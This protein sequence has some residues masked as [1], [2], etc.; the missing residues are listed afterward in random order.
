MEQFKSKLDTTTISS[1]SKS[2]DILAKVYQRENIDSQVKEILDKVS[3]RLLLLSKA[4]EEE[5]FDRIDAYLDALFSNIVKTLETLI[6]LNDKN[7]SEAVSFMESAY[8]TIQQVKII[9]DKAGLINEF[10]ELLAKHNQGSK[11]LH[12]YDFT[13]IQLYKNTA[14][15]NSS[16]QQENIVYT[17]TQI[18]IGDVGVKNN[19]RPEQE[20]EVP[21]IPKNNVPWDL[22]DHV[23]QSPAITEAF[24][25]AHFE[26]QDEDK[27][28]DDQ[29]ISQEQNIQKEDNNHSQGMEK[30]LSDTKIIE[31]VPVTLKAGVKAHSDSKKTVENSD[32]VLS[33]DQQNQYSESVNKDETILVT[34]QKIDEIEKKAKDDNQN[35]VTLPQGQKDLKVT[36]KLSDEE[37]FSHLPKTRQGTLIME[38]PQNRKES[39]SGIKLPVQKISDHKFPKVIINISDEQIAKVEKIEKAEVV[40]PSASMQQEEPSLPSTKKEPKV[41][42][43]ISTPA[44]TLIKQELNHSEDGLSPLPEYF[45]KPSDYLKTKD[46]STLLTQETNHITH[47]KRKRASTIA[48]LGALSLGGAVGGYRI[49][50]SVSNTDSTEAPNQ[51]NKLAT[52]NKDLELQSK[53]SD[54]KTQSQDNKVKEEIQTE[55]QSEKREKGIY[56]MDFDAPG[57]NQYLAT[58][59]QSSGLVATIKDIAGQVKV[60]YLQD[61]QEIE[62]AKAKGKFVLTGKETD[63]EKRLVMMEAFLVHALKQ[64]I[65]N[66]WVRGFF[67][68][69][70][71]SLEYFKKTGQWEKNGAD[72]GARKFFELFQTPVQLVAPPD[73]IG[74]APDIDPKSNPVLEQMKTAAPTFKLA[75]EEAAR[76][77]QQE[78]DPSKLVVYNDFNEIKTDICRRIRDIGIKYKDKDA[79]SGIAFMHKA[80]CIK[81]N[82]YNNYLNKSLKYI[83]PVTQDQKP[84]QYQ[85]TTPQKQVVP[86]GGPIFNNMINS[87]FRFELDQKPANDNNEEQTPSSQNEA[88]ESP[89]QDGIEKTK[90]AIRS[91]IAKI[92]E[93]YLSQ[94]VAK[95]K[96]T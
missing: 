68:N 23:A 49:Y 55:S 7:R 22:I 46:H 24:Q 4:F 85:T 38:K 29:V 83:V 35:A 26:I 37:A 92:K 76:Q 84:A 63:I 41:Q 30:D 58:I 78:T 61:N 86:Q 77:M 36:T 2:F 59:K 93:K 57:Y 94:L 56:K 75:F 67:Q 51:S 39:Q 10:N 9:F 62:A 44:P 11:S 5:D 87:P 40:Q 12:E 96:N 79:R 34:E 18:G 81:E 47:K 71:T 48:L 14:N 69:Q 54:T 33:I 1:I 3:Q 16:K 80:W 72:L 70:L 20:I 89:I 95:P 8:R 13:L 73:I 74:Y 27:T 65:D 6:R 32:T 15:L 88:I 42:D 53:T 21:E 45:P 52:N 28:I 19:L 64:D 50:Q 82:S 60:D 90:L 17:K 31:Q 66:K 91:S 43:K 25:K